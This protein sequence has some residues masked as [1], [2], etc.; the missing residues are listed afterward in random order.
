VYHSKYIFVFAFTDAT[1][2]GTSLE[3]YVSG[4]KHCLHSLSVI[5]LFFHKKW[6]LKYLL[7]L[8]YE[9]VSKSFRTES[10][11]KYTLATISTRLEAIQ[12]VMAAKFTRLTHKIVI[13]FHTVAESYTFAVLSPGGQ[14]GN[15]WIHPHP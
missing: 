12:M 1:V 8:T 6:M 11:T 7:L 4:N 9:C 10:I 5:R 14:F 15:F 13:Q 3:Y 2:F